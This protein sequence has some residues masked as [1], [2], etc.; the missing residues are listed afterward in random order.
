MSDCSQA[1][2]SIVWSLASLLVSVSCLSLPTELQKR[3][4]RKS[5]KNEMMMSET[6]F[7]IKNVT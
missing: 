3:P 1:C 5:E 2:A 6:F 7:I 4:L